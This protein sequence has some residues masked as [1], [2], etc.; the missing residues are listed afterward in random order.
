[1]SWDKEI[2]E[3]LKK[4]EFALQQGGKDNVERQHSKGLLTIRERITLILDDNTFEEIGPGAGGAERDKNGGLIK[5]NPANFVLG[6]GKINGRDCVIGGEDFTVK[7][8]SPTEAGLRKSIYI[9]DLAIQNLVPLVRLHQGGGGSVT[10]ASGNT[11]V[12]TSPV[13]NPPRFKTVAQTL[14][15]IP[16]ATAALGAV[17]GLPAA[18]LVASHFSIMTKNNSQV[19]IAGPKVV[20]RALG[21]NVTKEDMG[22]AHIHTR[23]GVVDN[24]AEDET[25]ALAQIKIFLSEKK[26]FKILIILFNFFGEIKKTI[27]Q[28]NFD[29]I[30][31]SSVNIFFFSGKNHRRKIYLRIH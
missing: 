18:R 25:D 29:K 15:A 3:I 24:I 23:N 2:N 31:K 14:Q 28:F 6:F 19:L 8:G 26:V 17:A 30:A 22:G 7:G 1:M 27:E 11:Q 5:F 16:V 9:E 13:Y 20:E 21:Q 4:K 12:S 10:G